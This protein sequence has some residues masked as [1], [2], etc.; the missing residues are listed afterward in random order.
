[1]LPKN[2]PETRVGLAGP[3]GESGGLGGEQS[4][5]Q[6][7]RLGMKTSKI[8]LDWSSFRDT[9]PDVRTQALCFFL[10]LFPKGLIKQHVLS[11]GMK[12]KVA[13]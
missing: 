12:M 3:A 10:P 9:C 1:M 2:V 6:K 13:E 4:L 8:L 11:G 5:H 7:Q